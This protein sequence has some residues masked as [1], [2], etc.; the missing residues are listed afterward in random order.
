MKTTYPPREFAKLVS[1][2]VRTLQKWDCKGIL[3]AKRTPTG[4]RFY[5]HEQYLE[6]VG[7]VAGEKSICVGYVRVSSQSQSPDLKNQKKALA[8]FCAVSKMPPDL[9]IED[10]GSGLNYKR[11]GFNRLLE[12]VESGSIHTIIIAHKDRLVRFG[13]EW[14][15]A[16]CQKHGARIFVMEDE[17]LSPEEEMVKDLMVIVHCFSCRLYGLRSYKKDLKRALDQ[18]N[19]TDG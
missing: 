1:Y 19:S 13:Y 5:T 4:R 12:M 2:T 17:S 16:F 14:F 7:A 18:K 10:I 15:R 8:R 9:W 3:I 6:F 11:K